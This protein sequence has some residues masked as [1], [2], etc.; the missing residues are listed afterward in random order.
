[1]QINRTAAMLTF[2]IASPRNQMQAEVFLISIYRSANYGCAFLIR[3][4]RRRPRKLPGFR[5]FDSVWQTT[6]GEHIIAFLGLFISLFL[7]S[8]L[9]SFILLSRSLYLTYLGLFA[10]VSLS[11]R[12]LLSGSEAQGHV[13]NL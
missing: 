9:F 5:R 2:I 10:T 3:T 11:A 12:S 4:F 13:L 7:L 8:S 1:M 6:Y